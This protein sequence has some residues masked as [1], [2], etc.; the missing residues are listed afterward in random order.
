MLI[1][2][3]INQIKQTTPESCSALFFI[4][5]TIFTLS[6]V[7]IMFSLVLLSTRSVADDK[8]HLSP[9][10]NSKVV[11]CLVCHSKSGIKI[12]PLRPNI[13]GQKKAYIV[14]QVKAIR[15]GSRQSPTMKP[16][17]EKLSDEDIYR[18]ADYFAKQTFIKRESE[19]I[20]LAGKNV[21]A[22]CVSCH[23]MTGKTVNESW[24]NLAGQNKEYL[25]K[26]LLDIESGKRNSPQMSVIVKELTH[27]EMKD[28]SEYYSQIAVKP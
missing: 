6:K 17:V 22:N 21:R 9:F 24:P 7:L 4:N 1:S 10:L 16:V 20:N 14:S 18:I 2:K 5:K 23:G 15:D 12:D 28:V 26:Q 11:E 8:V 19:Q 13:L 3:L 25:Y 27:Q